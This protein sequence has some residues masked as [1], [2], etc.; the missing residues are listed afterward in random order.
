[1]RC[2]RNSISVSISPRPSIVVFG[3]KIPS[4]ISKCARSKCGSSCLT[5]SASSSFVFTKIDGM[6][7]INSNVSFSRK[8][9]TTVNQK[10]LSCDK[11]GSI[12]GQEQN[13]L[14]NLFGLPNPSQQRTV[15][16]L[17]YDFVQ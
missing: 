17:P 8:T 2:T 10:S 14:G 1:M 4:A 13:H 12:A 5:F 9:V 16:L 7:V 3:T 15:D 11:T 6:I